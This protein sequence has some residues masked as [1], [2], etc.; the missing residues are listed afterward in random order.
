MSVVTSLWAITP[1]RTLAPAKGLG[2]A[3]IAAAL[4]LA[5]LAGAA[6]I[7]GLISRRGGGFAARASFDMALKGAGF[8]ALHTLSPQLFYAYYRTIIPGL[9]AQWV[10]RAPDWPRVTEALLFAP[11]ARLAEHLAALLFW[12][13]LLQAVWLQSGSRRRRVGAAILIAGA[14]LALRAL[15]A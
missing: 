11:E 3:L 12:G 7:S 9:P 2:L 4:C 15:T 5:I 13:L 14:P 8:A 10:I 1:T 6:R